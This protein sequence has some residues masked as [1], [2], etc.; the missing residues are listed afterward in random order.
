MIKL[1][2]FFIKSD[3][4]FTKDKIIKGYIEINDGLIVDIAPEPNKDIEILDYENKIVAPGYFDTHIHGYDGHDVMDLDEEGILK[5]SEG[6]VNNGVTSFLPTTLTDSEEKLEKACEVI[7][8]VKDRCKGA[9]IQGIFFEGPF[10]TTKH[11]GAQNPKYMQEPSM[12]KFKKWMEK[13]NNLIKKIALAPEKEG[14]LEF[15][16]QISKKEPDVKVA[17]GHSDASYEIAR[18]A[19]KSGASIFVHLYNG[20]SPLHHR[21]PGMVGA[22]LSS[23]EAY[24]EI[25]CDGHH[26][27]PA[28][29]RVA[30]NSKS[31]DKVILITDCM[32]AGGKEEGIYKLG[33]FD[34]KVQ[35]GCAKLV[36]GGSLAGSIL[37]MEKAVQNVVKWGL[38]DALGAINMA[39]IIPANS[40]G[41]SDKIG[42]IEK[43]KCADIN[44]LDDDLNVIS[45]FI[46]G[47]K[48][49]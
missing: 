26:V 32:R 13:S 18:E 35:E 44:I 9:K 19:I 37:T 27:H 38:I 7:A 43:G 34:V 24:A 41:L 8:K 5:I 20:M 10:F 40:L 2:N 21:N 47:V 48:V 30:L 14:S 22:A 49:I 17:L 1:S 4:I 36:D 6:I 3:K 12:E 15:I 46:D 23:D 25:I 16:K 11:K 39:T 28:A 31:K 29:I 45:T 33:D 42:S